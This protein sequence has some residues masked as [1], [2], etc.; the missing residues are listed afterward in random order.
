[1]TGERSHNWKWETATGRLARAI[2]T[3]IGRRLL[4][5]GQACLRW[6]LGACSLCGRDPGFGSIDRH[7][8][9]CDGPVRYCSEI[10]RNRIRDRLS[11]IPA[12]R[13]F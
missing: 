11:E 1:V 10:E 4:R 12:K 2:L 3:W 8:V 5:T 6:S 7:G 13:A 9:R